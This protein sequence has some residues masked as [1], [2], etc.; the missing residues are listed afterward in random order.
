MRRALIAAAAAA[1]VLS[2]TAAAVG[3]AL[4]AGDNGTSLTDARGTTYS[5]SLVGAST[6]V[7][8][9]GAAT[10]T[11]TIPGHFGIQYVTLNGAKTGLSADGGVLALDD[12]VSPKGVL[13]ARSRIAVVDTRTLTLRALVKLR[14]D[15]TVDAL[16]PNGYTVYLIHHV[17]GG[18]D[19]R[20]QVV[21]YDVRARRLVPHVIA[22]RRQEGWTMAGWP[23]ARTATRNGAWVFT[24]YRPEHNYP[25]IHALDTVHRRAICVALPVDWTKSPWIS[26][27]V[28]A[29]T[30]RGLE[31]QSAGHRT[32]FVLDLRT[33]RLAPLP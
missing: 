13:R 22:D 16:S 14:G 11:A 31:V 21:S 25:F 28:L 27:A 10:R 23:V 30:K 8:A 24:L 2:Q 32:R 17:S 20:Y 26:S 4:W 5:V 33:F 19:A 29:V 18:A 9:H 12:N 3:P 7:V 6:R 15:Y 1:L